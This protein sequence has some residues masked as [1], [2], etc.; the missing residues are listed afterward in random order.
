MEI[1]G[2][3]LHLYWVSITD[4]KFWKL[5]TALGKDQRD[6]TSWNT[7]KVME[8]CG[9]TRAAE[10]VR[11]HEVWTRTKILSLNICYFVTILR[12]VAICVLFL[13]SLGKKGVFWGVKSRSFI[14]TWYILV[15]TRKNGVFVA[16]IVNMRLRKFFMAIFALAERL[17][18]S[19]TLN[20]VYIEVLSLE[21]GYNG[22]ETGCNGV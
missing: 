20:Y 21:E 18:T 6:L 19:A 12:L 8:K 22:I 2:Q 10:V 16:K 1:C 13:K 11:R 9:Q 14:V 5:S 17:P 3:T 15:I 7:D 4:T